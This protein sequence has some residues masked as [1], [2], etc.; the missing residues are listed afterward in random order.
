MKYVAAGAILLALISFFRVGVL[1]CKVMG[2]ALSPRCLLIGS[3]L[4]WPKSGKNGEGK[5]KR[6]SSR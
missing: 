2:E 4:S 3:F 6:N 5:A 1:D